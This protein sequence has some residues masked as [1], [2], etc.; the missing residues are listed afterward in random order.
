MGIDECEYEPG[1][2]TIFEGENETGKTSH[3]RALLGLLGAKPGIRQPALANDADVGE[4]HV[5]L[6][7]QYS[8]RKVFERG[9]RPRLIVKDQRGKE[10]SAPQDY[11]D[12]LI[13]ALAAN[14]IRFME[15]A[16]SPKERLEML[17]RVAKIELN[18]DDFEG[19]IPNEQRARALALASEL[20]PF[21][22]I[23]HIR[24]S[25]FSSRTN[26]NSEKTTKTKHAGQL[27]EGLPPDNDVDHEKV[28]DEN[29]QRQ[30]ELVA[31]E[32]QTREQIARLHAEQLEQLHTNHRDA[33]GHLNNA[34]RA[35]DTALSEGIAQLSEDKETALATSLS[36]ILEELSQL[37]GK[38][39]TLREKVSIQQRLEVTRRSIRAADGEIVE[40][41]ERSEGLTK[42]LKAIEALKKR[43]LGDI[44]IPGLIIRGD[45]IWIDVDGRGPITYTDLNTAKRLGIALQVSVMAADGAGIVCIDGIERL[46]QKHLE[47]FAQAAEASGLQFFATRVLLDSDGKLAIRT[48]S[49]A[50]AER[51]RTINVS[52]TE[53]GADQET[54]GSKP[55]D[56][57]AP[58][59]KG[60]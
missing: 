39:G 1:T 49:S 45:D 3:M 48:I 52:T 19:I 36:P 9:K 47:M 10:V 58:D 28:L 8:I 2:L 59:A 14:P 34:V 16:T 13:S 24:S 38:E 42:R 30:S 11:V 35:L 21:G 56:S 25:I 12:R 40:L 44:P 33:V 22:A 20:G 17:L 57:S 7:D 15:D 31:Q 23:E 60:G 55:A 29:V 41:K 26:V 50:D 18:S 27:R 51:A 4:I 43:K 37:T 6:D 54:K 53:K 32:T 5:E 46:D